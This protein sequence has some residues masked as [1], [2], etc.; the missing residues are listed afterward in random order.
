MQSPPPAVAGA[1]TRT[2]QTFE[3]HHI[4]TPGDLIWIWWPTV[5]AAGGDFQHS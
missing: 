2:V 1:L 4:P 5:M 3:S